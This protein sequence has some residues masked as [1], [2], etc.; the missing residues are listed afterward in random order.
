MEPYSFLNLLSQV[1]DKTVKPFLVG[2]FLFFCV[3]GNASAA[4]SKE[5]KLKA[6][7]LLNFTKFIEWP[8]GVD[9]Q[10]VSSIRICAEESDEFVTFLSDMVRNSKFAGRVPEVQSLAW[11]TASRC[12]LMYL[13]SIKNVDLVDLHNVVI[14]VNSRETYF[15]SVAIVFYEKD[16]RLRF[17]VDLNYVNSLE[18]NFSSELLKLAKIRS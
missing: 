5:D 15:P 17:E 16:K 11:D 8:V 14:V 10:S 3:T 7:Y 1:V 6:A 9:N 13:T 4:L 2:L 18:V 12:N